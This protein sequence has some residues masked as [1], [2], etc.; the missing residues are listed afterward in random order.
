MFISTWLARVA[1]T[2]GPFLGV[3]LAGALGGSLWLLGE[4][5][6]VVGSQIG[7]PESHVSDVLHEKAWA[8]DKTATAVRE[9]AKV[10]F[11]SVTAYKSASMNDEVAVVDTAVNEFYAALEPHFGNIRGLRAA[12]ANRDAPS[13]HADRSKL[14]RL[15]AW[16]G[17]V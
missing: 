9:R 17:G 7:P 4:S 12:V 16:I 1:V 15:A 2:L 8:F 10:T 13:E 11:E 5:A 6:D 14:Q 3:A